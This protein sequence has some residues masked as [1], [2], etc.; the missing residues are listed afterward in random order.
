MLKVWNS[1]QHEVGTQ[2]VLTALP[3]LPPPHAVTTPTTCSVQAL[4]I[5]FV[6]PF[7]I[8]LLL[9]KSSSYLHRILYFQNTFMYIVLFIPLN[10]QYKLG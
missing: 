9:L 3:A 5:L 10:N 6:A 2:H 7:L 4:C 1:T 8:N